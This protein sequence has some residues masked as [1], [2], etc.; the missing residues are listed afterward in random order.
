MCRHAAALILLPL[1]LLPGVVTAST[2]HQPPQSAALHSLALRLSDIQHV[3]GSGLTAGSAG[4]A[5]KSIDVACANVPT[6]D[7]ANGFST[8]NGAPV[9]KNGLLSITAVLTQYKTGSGPRCNFAYD[10]VQRKTLGAALG[11]VVSKLNGVGQQAVLIR[12]DP[13]KN[14]PGP[15]V[16]ALDARFIRGR[17]L[18]LVVVQMNRK[19]RPADVTA[20]ARAVDSR[21][22]H[23]G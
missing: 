9:H 8:S 16:Y 7:F 23:N 2:Q 1:F 3:Y 6:I 19:V 10:L 21:V 20:L 4:S 14:E 11:G 22:K 18:V 5:K 13:Q 17:Y 15:P 12:L